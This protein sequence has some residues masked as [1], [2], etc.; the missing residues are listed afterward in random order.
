MRR[1]AFVLE[2]D[3]AEDEGARRAAALAEVICVVEA[4]PARVV[5]VLADDARGVVVAEV[6][7]GR[8]P[9]QSVF[10]ELVLDLTER[11]RASRVLRRSG[12]SE[13]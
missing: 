4:F 10:T 11:R 7:P 12:P 1:I 2:L 3:I 13:A 6:E 9:P 5:V 8:E